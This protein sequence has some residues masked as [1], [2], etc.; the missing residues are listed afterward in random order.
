[1]KPAIILALALS[2]LALH[3]HAATDSPP[4]PR[5]KTTTKGLPWPEPDPKDIEKLQKELRSE[6]SDEFSIKCIGPWV[7]ATDLPAEDA[8]LYFDG[9]ISRSAAKLQIQLFNKKPRSKPVKVYLFKDNESYVIHNEKL[10]QEKPGTPYGFFSEAKN[11]LVMNIGTGGGT[12][13]HEMAHAMARED[14]PGIPSWLNEGIGSLFEASTVNRQGRIV[15][16]TNW[17]LPGLKR[18]LL[19]KEEV[20]F[21]D[22]LSMDT[23]TFYGDRSGSNYASA[24]YLMQWLQDNDKLEDFYTRI[25]DGKDTDAIATLRKVF[26]DKHTVD[27]LEK[28]CYAWANALRF[29][30]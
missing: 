17:R 30:Q 11:A 6:L 4:M 14:F 10:W 26:D 2:L 24:R 9:T 21:K 1:M 3:G 25:R 20:H 7:V 16:V 12:L 13:V 8:K 22:L 29:K 27:E 28:K 18:D 23:S 15:G 5:P 19:N